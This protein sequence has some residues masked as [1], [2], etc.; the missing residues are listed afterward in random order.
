MT[1]VHL[2]ETWAKLTSSYFFASTLADSCHCRTFSCASYQLSCAVVLVVLAAAAAVAAADCGGV[3]DVVA[4][5]GVVVGVVVVDVILEHVLVS[6]ALCSD[7]CS[8]SCA[9]S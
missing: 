5:G 9:C 4:G 2:Y 6:V 3:V 1:D 8:R 7:Y